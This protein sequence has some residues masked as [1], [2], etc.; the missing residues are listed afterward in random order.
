MET[1]TMLEALECSAVLLLA[2]AELRSKVSGNSVL[3][4]HEIIDKVITL[5]VELPGFGVNSKS[6]KKTLH[7]YFENIICDTTIRAEDK[8]EELCFVYTTLLS[9]GE[10]NYED[11]RDVS[12]V[13]NALAYLTTSIPEPF[14]KVVYEKLVSW[15]KKVTESVKVFWK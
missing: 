8:L 1:K 6:A 4:K 10:L 12:T 5:F 14:S 7:N 2:D 9:S 11:K 15:F 13:D 3:N